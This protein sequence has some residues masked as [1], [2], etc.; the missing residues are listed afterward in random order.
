MQGK[1]ILGSL[2]QNCESQ[3][4]VKKLITP[5]LLYASALLMSF[6]LVTVPFFPS[7]NVKGFNGVAK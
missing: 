2:I 5:C 1:I 3:Q 4:C 7:R 6:S